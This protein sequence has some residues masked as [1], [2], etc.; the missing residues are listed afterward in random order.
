MAARNG[1]PSA[2]HY[3]VHHRNLDLG[4]D[5]GLILLLTHRRPRREVNPFHL[6]ASTGVVG[7]VCCPIGRDGHVANCASS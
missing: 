3:A 6:A 4:T 5:A 2:V 7:W 1:S